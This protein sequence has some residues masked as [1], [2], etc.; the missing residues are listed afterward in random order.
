MHLFCRHLKYWKTTPTK[1]TLV[2]GQ[3]T[4]SASLPMTQNWEERLIRQK[5]MLPC[6]RTSA[7][8]RSELTGNSWSSTKRSAKF[9][10]GR[11]T[12][13]C[14]NIYWGLLSWKGAL[15][16]R[17]WKSWWTPS[18]ALASNVPL[19]Q[20]KLTVS[21][22]ALG[23]ALPA[24]QGRGSCPSSQHRWGHVWSTASSAGLLSTREMD[25][26]KRVQQKGHE[27]N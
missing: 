19:P 16:R 25:I 1:H 5:V 21:W 27:D 11:V 20:R 13:P 17:T 26:L 2:T 15:Q 9:C 7:D 22:A 8:W 18:W 24:D 14:A 4:T 3:S 6:R 10:T 12:T 23:A